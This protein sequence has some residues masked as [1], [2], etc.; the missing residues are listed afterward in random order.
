MIRTSRETS[1]L[2]FCIGKGKCK[3]KV[4]AENVLTVGASRIPYARV[5]IKSSNW[6]WFVWVGSQVVVGCRS[7]QFV[8]GFRLVFHLTHDYCGSSLNR[9]RDGDVGVIFER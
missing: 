5:Y 7:R 4:N 8:E 6:F 2:R 1:D 9:Y 3:Q